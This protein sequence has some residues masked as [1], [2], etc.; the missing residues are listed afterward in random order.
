MSVIRFFGLVLGTVLIVA[1]FYYHR[2][3]R[4]SRSVF[5]LVFFV[6]LALVIVS[7]MPDSVNWLPN[8]LNLGEYGVGRILALSICA[9]ILATLLALYS[10]SRTDSLRYLL[11]RII[12]SGL[13]DRLLGDGD[14][15]QQRIKP[16]MVIIPALNEA[17]NLEILLPNIPPRIGDHDLGVLVIDD[18]STDDTSEMA[19]KLGVL[20]ARNPVPRGQGAALR[21]GYQVLARCGVEVGV[22]MDAD[23]QHRPSDIARLVEPILTGQA[24]LVIGS[25]VKGSADAVSWTRSMGVFSLSHLISVL[26]GHY[27]TD[28][29]SGFK[30]FRMN[31]ISKLNLRED[32]FQA[33]EVI[34]EAAKKG[35]RIQEVPI[36]IARREHGTSR[37][38][39]NFLYGLFFFK[40][41]LKTWWR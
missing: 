7:V 12:C 6:G 1:N 19:T 28:C 23:N 35:L 40:T 16:I 37:K 10:K 32:Q 15:I 41:M 29:S 2:G 5:T 13:T 34:I 38:G 24:D 11:D 20:A 14:M 36:H 9:S 31:S 26:S 3:S 27:I 25:R 33:S 4:W 22:T 8:L 18:G 21:V 17:S 39:G 30:A